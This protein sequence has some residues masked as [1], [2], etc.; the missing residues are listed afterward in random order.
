MLS[1]G[2]NETHHAGSLFK[3]FSTC[4]FNI[5]WNC[6]STDELLNHP[7]VEIFFHKTLF[8]TFMAVHRGF[9]AEKRGTM[10]NENC[11]LGILCALATSAHNN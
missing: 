10:L 9:V 5:C 8:R 6:D 11:L 4:V 3:L 7:W 2:R 1:K